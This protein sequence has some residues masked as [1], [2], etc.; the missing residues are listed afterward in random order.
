MHTLAQVRPA[1]AHRDTS[2]GRSLWAGRI[3]SGV[4]AALLTADSLGKLAQARPVLEGT[5]Y[6]FPT[7]IAALAWYGMMLRD[8]RVRAFVPWRRA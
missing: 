6:L 2:T 1:A 8:P 5:G 7:Y 4:V 3:I